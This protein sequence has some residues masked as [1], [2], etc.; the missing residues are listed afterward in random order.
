MRSLVAAA[1]LLFLTGSLAAHGQPENL[2]ERPIA[3]WTYTVRAG[4][5]FSEIARRMGVSI[6]ALAAAN[7]MSPP[8]IL[9]AGQVLKRPDPAYVPPRRAT[10]PPLTPQQPPAKQQRLE[11]G[12]GSSSSSG[13]AGKEPAAQRKGW[14]ERRQGRLSTR[15]RRGS[16]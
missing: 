9:R 6:E 16:S 14:W 13:G 11:G 10:P 5:R 4:D 12:G 2:L 1:V 3:A 8:Y 7:R 15:T